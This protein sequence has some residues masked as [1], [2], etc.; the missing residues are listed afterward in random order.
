MARI[1]I[2]GATGFLGGQAAQYLSAAGHEIL[3]LGRSPEKLAMLESRG[4]PAW[5][6]DLGSEEAGSLVDTM[7][8]ADALVHCA[9]LSAPWGARQH[10]LRANVTGTEAALKLA[11]ALHVRRFVNISSPA[12]YFAPRDQL[13]VSED[14][15]LPPPINHYAETKSIAEKRVLA[16][17][18]FGPVNLRPRGIYGRGDTALLPRLLEAAR[19]GPLPL[20][21][22]GQAAIDLTHV[23]DVVRAIEAALLAGPE[24]TGQTF[25]VSGGE[26]VSVRR[27]VESACA[28][29]GEPVRWRTMPL[30]PLMVVARLADAVQSRRPNAREP[31]LTPYALGLFAYR[32]SLDIGK[33]RRMLDWRPAVTFE[34]GL[35]RTFAELAER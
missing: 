35:S 34:E 12:V 8:R 20:L 32:Q 7:G 3:A 30:R 21:R 27:I 1:V 5:R 23:S 25:N 22:G 26:I 4:I 11:R 33:A 24:V 13:A 15:P 6:V 10:F 19:R 9:A 17:T 29:A 2:T 16:C 28:A 14:H 18:E 31:R